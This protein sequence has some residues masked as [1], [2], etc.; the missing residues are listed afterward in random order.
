MQFIER[1]VNEQ[2]KFPS[3]PIVKAM[4]LEVEPKMMEVRSS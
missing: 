3:D 1:A 2:A 4:G